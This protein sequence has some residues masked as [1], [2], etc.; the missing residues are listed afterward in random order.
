FEHGGHD[1]ALRA[2]VRG[3]F[4]PGSVPADLRGGA[5][6]AERNQAFAAWLSEPAHRSAV[7]RAW[8]RTERGSAQARLR[9]ALAASRL[10]AAAHAETFDGLSIGALKRIEPDLRYGIGPGRFGV[11]T[12]RES[13]PASIVL[14]TRMPDGAPVCIS[15]NN[16][17]DVGYGWVDPQT[18]AE[19]VEE[20][21]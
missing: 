16:G 10:Y 1:E 4:G 7:V 21:W 2:W 13:T 19:C 20:S 12:L 14:V 11:V 9:E 8:L 17:G 6:A 3:E 15:L 5:T 18:Y